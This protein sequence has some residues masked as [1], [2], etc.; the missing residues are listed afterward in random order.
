MGA[1]YFP[2]SLTEK[3]EKCRGH[4][5]SFLMVREESGKGSEGDA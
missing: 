2:T 3:P 5:L 4:Y 1:M